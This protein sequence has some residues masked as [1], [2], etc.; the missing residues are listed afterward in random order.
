MR[1][2]PGSIVE[3]LVVAA[4]R[5]PDKEC[6]RFEGRIYRYSDVLLLARR[7]SAAFRSRGLAAGDRVALFLDNSLDFLGSY[8]GVQM[9]GGIVVLVNT[10]YRQVELRHILAD[11]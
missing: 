11:A 4:D 9:A 6:L 8:F 2:R 1:T 10:Q 5:A 3:A 7:W